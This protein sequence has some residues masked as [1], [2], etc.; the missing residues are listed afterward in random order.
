MENECSLMY[1]LHRCCMWY[2][3]RFACGVGQA[4]HVASSVV[5]CGWRR[6]QPLGSGICV[7]NSAP[8][9]CNIP[10]DPPPPACVDNGP[11]S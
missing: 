3:V 6:V 5:L 1:T 4:L 11:Q 7:A 8:Q 9:H 10:V 2:G